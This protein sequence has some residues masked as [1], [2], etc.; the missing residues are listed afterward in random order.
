M[1]QNI[2][3]NFVRQESG[4]TGCSPVRS[5]FGH[6]VICIQQLP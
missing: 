3:N 2:H 5:T 4:N 6:M 1:S